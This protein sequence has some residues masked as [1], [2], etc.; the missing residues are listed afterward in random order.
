[1]EASH[2][3][4][5]AAATG[6]VPRSTASMGARLRVRG[7]LFQFDANLDSYL[8]HQSTEVITVRSV[9]ALTLAAPARAVSHQATAAH[10]CSAVDQRCGR[11]VQ[12]PSTAIARHKAQGTRHKAEAQAQARGTG[13]WAGPIGWIG[14][15][16]TALTCVSATP[17]LASPRSTA[18]GTS[19]SPIVFPV[20][21]QQRL[22]RSQRTARHR[23]AQHGTAQARRCECC[24]SSGHTR[25]LSLFSP[26]H[27]PREQER[28]TPSLSSLSR[29]WP[30]A[31][32]AR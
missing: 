25:A 2:N 31:T 17:T 18:P 13:T 26:P 29:S 23:S 12:G 22:N 7:T 24:R 20:E 10:H 30:A 11:F 9:D 16:T 21:G 1:M 6:T 14:C 28:E 15:T 8:Y 27:Q 19:K 4:G 3:C 32:R 5:S